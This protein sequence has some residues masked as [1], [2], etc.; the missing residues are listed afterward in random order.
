MIKLMEKME[1]EVEE[2]TARHRTAA[3][4][5]ER[6]VAVHSLAVRRSTAVVAVAVAVGAV[7]YTSNSHCI[8]LRYD[9][10]LR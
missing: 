8:L 3:E 5:V 6:T 4:A 1:E 9:G 2:A 7:D 10:I